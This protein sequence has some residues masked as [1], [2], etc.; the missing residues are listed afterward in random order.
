MKF[1]CDNI[2]SVV[3]DELEGAT[4][5]FVAIAFFNPDSRTLEAISCLKK[6]RL[7]F[8]GEYAITNPYKLEMLTSA[9][10][11]CIPTD[12]DSGRLH[13][14]VLIVKRRDGSYWVLL[15]SANLTHQGMFS[16]QEACVAM[17]STDPSDEA[18]VQEIR[19]WFESLFQTGD[20]PDLQQAK[21]IFESRSQHRLEPRPKGQVKGNVGY[22][23]LKT[24]SG[25]TGEQHWPM[26]LAESVIAIGWESLPL[27]PSKV[28]EL[29]LQAALTET[30]PD[31]SRKAAQV[32]ASNIRRFVGLK[33]NDIILLCRGYTSNQTKDVH[34]HGVARV[35][36]PFRAEPRGNGHWRFRY[37]AVI[38]DINI[39]LPIHIVK[40][41]LAK[42]S[43][44]QT[45]HAL[46]KADFDRI[47]SELKG[48]GVHV[49]V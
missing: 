12:S 9:E 3:L 31:Y 38:Q 7:I 13:A 28:S 44:R 43:L 46:R 29:Q 30:Y 15:G 48:F 25:S 2:G 22:W 33:V 8:S 11:R 41:A 42:D 36:G 32:A 1:L 16:N 40:S 6:L 4:E 5:A 17:D 10:L 47:A 24:T 37:D 14:K 18:S 21:L 23:A 45:I 26:F 49:E 39:D 19:H 35:S 27:D 34:I 20:S